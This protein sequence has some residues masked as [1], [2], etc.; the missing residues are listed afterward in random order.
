L[1]PEPDVSAR[2]LPD[3][4]GQPFAFRAAAEDRLLLVYFGYTS[5]PDVC[6]TTLSDIRAALNRLGA[7]AGKVDLAMVTVDPDRDTPERLRAYVQSF[8]GSANALATTDADA[9]KRAADAFGVRYQVTTAPSGQVEVSHSAFLYAVDAR[10]RVVVQ[11]PFG[12]HAPQLATD[13]GI[14]LGRDKTRST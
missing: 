12:V 3:A 9:L 10:G 1:T 14:L 2:S 5:C 6:P 4:T 8:V 11:W 7:R 13:I